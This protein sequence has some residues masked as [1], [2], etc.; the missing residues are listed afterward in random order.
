MSPSSRYRSGAIALI[1]A[2]LPGCAISPNPLSNEQLLTMADSNSARVTADQETFSG[3]ITLYEAMARAL[4]YNLDYRVE[5]L[6]QSL[7]ATE[8]RLS[9]FNMLPSTVSNSGYVTRDSYLATGERN[10]A[11]GVERRPTTTS[12]DRSLLTGDFTFSWNI[13]DF[14]LSY[15]RAHQAADKVLIAEEARRKAIQRIIEDVRTAYWRAVSGERM[16]AKLAAIEG[17]TKTVLANTRQLFADRD[18]SPITVLT[19]ERELVEIRRTAQELARELSV[20]KA[21]LAALMNVQPETHQY[22][23]CDLVRFNDRTKPIIHL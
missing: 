4:K 2:L 18:T 22:L 7:R 21:Q 9:H 16:L 14:G 19:Y 17:R 3:P 11:T 20:S 6:Q 5:S 8:L 23:P 1:T 10:L 12:Y 13:L 15:V